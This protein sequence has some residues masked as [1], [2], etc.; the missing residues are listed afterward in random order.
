MRCK[1]AIEFIF[2]C[3]HQNTKKKDIA[4]GHVCARRNRKQKYWKVLCKIKIIFLMFGG[5]F[6]ARNFIRSENS[7]S[8]I[9]TL[10]RFVSEHVLSFQSPFSYSVSG[11][12]FT[13]HSLHFCSFLYHHWCHFCHHLLHL[14]LL[15]TRRF[16]FCLANSFLA[17]HSSPAYVSGKF[18]FF[19]DG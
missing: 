11:S 3:F 4:S 17:T 10:L 6:H 7:K 2:T 5:F 19:N 12:I 1:R 14:Q 15:F 16:F 18:L 9:I 8:R 13:S